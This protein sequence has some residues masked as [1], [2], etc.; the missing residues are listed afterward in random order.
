MDLGRRQSPDDGGR[1]FVARSSPEGPVRRQ[2]RNES[3]RVR[4]ART[5]LHAGPEGGDLGVDCGRAAHD[6][7][8]RAGALQDLGYVGGESGHLRPLIG[9]GADPL[10]ALPI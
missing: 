2:P 4:V 8:D 9:F 3:L 1:L 10:G 5:A 7:I 6:V